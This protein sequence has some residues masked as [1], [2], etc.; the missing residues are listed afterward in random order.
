MKKI[1]FI[2]S[3]LLSVS[4]KAQCIDF[5][6]DTVPKSLRFPILVDSLLMFK[7]LENN[8]L[9]KYKGRNV[10][11]SFRFTLSPKGLVTKLKHIPFKDSETASLLF[12]SSVLNGLKWRAGFLSKKNLESKMFIYFVQE[13]DTNNTKDS[14]G[15]VYL[16]VEAEINGAQMVVRFDRNATKK[17]F[18]KTKQSIWKF[19][20]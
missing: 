13:Y 9:P 20:E 18:M 4:L 16:K 14:V 17:V 5:K 2:L 8:F 19:A 11:L 12:I 1:F 7:R 3:L 15:K 6:Y 10:T